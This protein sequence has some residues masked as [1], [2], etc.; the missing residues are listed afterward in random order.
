MNLTSYKI[1]G[2]I[3]RIDETEFTKKGYPKRFL[4]VEVPT[5]YGDH[6]RSEILKFLVMGDETASIDFYEEGQFVEILFKLEGRFWTPPD[7]P[8]KKIH[9][10]S[11]RIVDIHK[12][13]NPF[14]GGEKISESPDDNSPDHLAELATN[15]KDW[16][17][18][19]DSKDPFEPQDGDLPF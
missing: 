3:Y 12:R 7:E 5:T 18:K 14:K 6:Q 11:L 10:S 2:T 8:D 9:L 19:Q 4:F 17:Q 1:A 16:T 13:D 15:V